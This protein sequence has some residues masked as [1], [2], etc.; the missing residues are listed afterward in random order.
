MS[1]AFVLP[2]WEE[3][4]EIQTTNARSFACKKIRVIDSEIPERTVFMR[5]AQLFAGLS[6]S[7]CLE[8]AERARPRV[9]ARNEL[10]FM[11]GQPFRTLVLVESGCVKLTRLSSNG[12]EVIVALRGSR[13]AI[14]LP[15]GPIACN[16]TCN[17]VVVVRC[18]ALTWDWLTLENLATTAQ[19]NR[20]ICSILTRQLQELQERYHEMAAE[21]V[22]RRL[23]CALLRLAKQFGTSTDEGTEIS[24]S[25][26]ELAQ[27]TGTTLFTVSRLISKWAEL[28][29]VLPR[30]EA[31]LVLNPE[32]LDFV[33]S[34]SQQPSQRSL[35]SLADREQARLTA[36]EV[37]AVVS[38]CA[39]GAP[40]LSVLKT[41]EQS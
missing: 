40:S 33:S 29:L 31:V 30:R 3:A 11:Q 34:I 16:H 10:L 18:K 28:G 2:S 22:G 39:N 12:N 37:L 38:K 5:A 24:I 25:R 14:D 41:A 32:R 21:N 9:F 19:L 36:G 26:Q 17:A 13:D 35:S 7:E 15:A 20:N 23:A 6:L 1:D 8:I 27:M 4:L